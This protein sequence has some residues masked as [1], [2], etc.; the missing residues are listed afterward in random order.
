M[1]GLAFGVYVFLV[2]DYLLGDNVWVSAGLG[3]LGAGVTGAMYILVSK[4]K[5]ELG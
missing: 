4:K 3:I 2:K 5:D 1:A